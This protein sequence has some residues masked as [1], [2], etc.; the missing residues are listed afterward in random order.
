MATM[1]LLMDMRQL[2]TV[3]MVELVC[4]LSSVLQTILRVYMI[5]L[6]PAIWLM[7]LQEYVVLIGSLHV[8][9]NLIL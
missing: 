2:D 1:P 9:K 8:S 7:V 3:P 4:L 5:L 6:L